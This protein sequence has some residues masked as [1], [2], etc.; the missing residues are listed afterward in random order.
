MF[1]RQ[2]VVGIACTTILQNEMEREEYINGLWLT[3][4]ELTEGAVKTEVRKTLQCFTARTEASF[5]E[6]T[7]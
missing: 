5:C 3:F 2:M 1:D 6:V 7:Y 4:N